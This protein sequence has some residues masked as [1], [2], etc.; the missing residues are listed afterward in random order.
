MSAIQ[1]DLTK[2]L[3]FKIIA[4]EIVANS[5]PVTV[6]AKLGEKEGI[7]SVVL[8]GVRTGAKVG[9]KGGDKAVGKAA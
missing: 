2:L 8:A 7:K 6:G 5:Q 4:G 9:S 3:G 1:L